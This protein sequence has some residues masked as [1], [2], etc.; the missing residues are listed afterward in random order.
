MGALWDA[1]EWQYLCGNVYVVGSFVC[2]CAFIPPQ[3]K[4][5]LP[6]LGITANAF[7]EFLN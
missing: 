1:S 3:H 7:A 6:F 5:K 4:F 2:V